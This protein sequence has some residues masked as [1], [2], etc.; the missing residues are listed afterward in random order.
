MTYFK[1]RFIERK[2]LKIYLTYLNTRVRESEVLCCSV[3][4]I[5][6]IYLYRLNILRVVDSKLYQVKR[7]QKQNKI[8]FAY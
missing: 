5:L 1:V 7:E 8:R 4:D 3:N 6:Y 2:Y